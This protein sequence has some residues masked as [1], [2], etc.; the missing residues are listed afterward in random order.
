LV[1]R[2]ED[3]EMNQNPYAPPSSAVAD[4][5]SGVPLERPKPVK[6][7]LILCW[8][9]LVLALP[10]IAEA[11]VQ[12]VDAGDGASSPLYYAVMGLFYVALL[13]LAAWVIV[14]IGRAR[15]WARIVYAV[16]TGLSLIS[17]ITSF[18]EILQRP[19]YS[20][21]VEL[22]STVMDLAIVVLLYLPA[23]NAWFRVRG[24]RLADGNT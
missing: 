5:E 2:D 24:R 1:S 8:I 16:L 6:L 22:L 21:P 15:N 4:V 17:T 18:P 13:V 3:V 7:A 11:S 9:S 20:G 19:W 10:L 12:E 23:A 14:M